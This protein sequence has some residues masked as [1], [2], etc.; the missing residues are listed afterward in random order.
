MS[1]LTDKVQKFVREGLA[2]IDFK[3]GNEASFVRVYVRASTPE[4]T[5][6]DFEAPGWI[7]VATSESSSFR[8]DVDRKEQDET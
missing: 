2:G 3:R 4:F 6:S 7:A 1:D 8:I 5:A